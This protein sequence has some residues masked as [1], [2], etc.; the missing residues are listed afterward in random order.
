M[1]VKNPLLQLLN[2]RKIPKND[3]YEWDIRHCQGNNNML[4]NYV[5]NEIKIVLMD[6]TQP[7]LQLL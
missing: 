7:L 3:F 5:I 6:I 4:K 1:K 2:Y